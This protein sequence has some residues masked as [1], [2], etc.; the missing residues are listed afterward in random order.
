MPRPRPR[1]LPGGQLRPADPD[2]RHEGSRT[3]G[4][5]RQAAGPELGVYAL[6]EYSSASSSVVVGTSRASSRFL[7]RGRVA[8]RRSWAHG[9]AAR[10]VA[11]FST[12]SASCS[13]GG[14]DGEASRS[15]WALWREPWTAFPAFFGAARPGVHPLRADGADLSGRSTGPSRP[16]RLHASRHS[17]VRE[18]TGGGRLGD[19]THRSCRSKGGH[20]KCG[21]RWKRGTTTWRLCVYCSS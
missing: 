8:A 1:W 5:G 12:T 14:A 21:G 13:V 19:R 20:K 18:D 6:L 10:T 7:A 17:R 15:V 4:G 11:P 9:S 16:C 2:H 3:Q